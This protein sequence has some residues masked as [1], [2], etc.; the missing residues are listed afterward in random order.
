MT[1]NIMQNALFTMQS[2]ENSI[3]Q[4]TTSL[5]KN[6]NELDVGKWT[7][8]QR[9]CVSEAALH[10]SN[11]FVPLLAARSSSLRKR[12]RMHYSIS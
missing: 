11:D 7:Q 2:H 8:L 12:D 5:K 6:W 1:T 4:P 3:D 10:T 9:S